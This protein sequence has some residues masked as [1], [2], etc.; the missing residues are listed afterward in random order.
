MFCLGFPGPVKGGVVND[1]L[2]IAFYVAIAVVGIASTVLATIWMWRFLRRRNMETLPA[3]LIV[4]VAA[5]L[6]FW[7]LWLVFD[8]CWIVVAA[9]RLVM[10][11]AG[12]EGRPAAQG[13]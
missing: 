13:G 5:I 4:T 1:V 2:G 8:V 12:G 9:V 10:R 3:A 6:A 7:G 11:A